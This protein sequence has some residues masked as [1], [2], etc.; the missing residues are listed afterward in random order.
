MTVLVPKYALLE[1]ERRWLV[2]RGSV[3]S[4]LTGPFRLIEDKY[5]A[6]GELRLRSISEA[7]GGAKV[8]KLGKKYAPVSP[9]QR[10]VVSVYL[11]EEEA[12]AISSLAG[13]YGRKQRFS[14]PPGSLDLYLVP[15]HPFAVFEVE[16]TS[17]SASAAYV[18]PSFVGEEVTG[19]AKYSGF[20]LSAA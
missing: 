9:G 1:I 19:D 20:A 2:P 14:V 3:V 6:G 7:S 13:R 10:P 8:F 15:E 11:S 17:K 16:F 12:R 5:L 4:L 18:P